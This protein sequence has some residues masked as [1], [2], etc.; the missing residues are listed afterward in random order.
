MS[1]EKIRLSGDGPRES[2]PT[3]NPSLERAQP[4]QAGISSTVY[5]V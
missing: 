1:D 3:V 4:K 2:L 5:I